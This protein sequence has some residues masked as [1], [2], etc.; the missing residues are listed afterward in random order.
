MLPI[1]YLN[2]IISIFINILKFT[3]INVFYIK[4]NI[5][6]Y[7]SNTYPLNNISNYITIYSFTFVIKLKQT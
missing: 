6:I 5:L 3:I 4:F 2:L 7:Y 1:N